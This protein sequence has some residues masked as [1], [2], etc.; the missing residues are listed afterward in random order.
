LHSQ[1]IHF[2]LQNFQKGN[3]KIFTLRPDQVED[4]LPKICLQAG[5]FQKIDLLLALLPDK[6]GSLYGY[7][8]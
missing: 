8:S 4:G 5:Q 7:I 3:P 6:N 2:D 1:S